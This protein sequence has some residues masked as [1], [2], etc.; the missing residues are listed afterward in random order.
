MWTI[1][2]ADS[3]AFSEKDGTPFDAPA[4]GVTV[5]VQPDPFNEYRTVTGDYYIFQPWGWEGVDLFGLWDY[6]AD[7]GPK[8]VKFGRTLPTRDFEKIFLKAIANG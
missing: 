3:G 2:Y 1:Y 6:L 7:P 8:A 4:R 5:I